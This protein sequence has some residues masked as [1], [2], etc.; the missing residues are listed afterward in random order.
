MNRTCNHMNVYID[1]FVNS[2]N[3]RH[4]STCHERNLVNN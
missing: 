2:S 4:K 3:K 1:F